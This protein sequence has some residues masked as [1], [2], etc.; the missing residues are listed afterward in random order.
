VKGKPNVQQALYAPPW[1]E[2]EADGR[3]GEP[4]GPQTVTA[5]ARQVARFRDWAFKKPVAKVSRQADAEAIRELLGREDV[6]IPVSERTVG[7]LVFVQGHSVRWAARTMR[8]TRDSARS[9][10]ERLRARVD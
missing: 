6:A 10:I 7:T 4:Y 5:Y 3:L 8:V 9:Y 1:R 2:L